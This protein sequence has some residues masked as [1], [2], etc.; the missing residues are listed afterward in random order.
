MRNGAPV[1][2]SCVATL[3]VAAA[4][5]IVFVPRAYAADSGTDRRSD[6]AVR[7][8]FAIKL[9]TRGYRLPTAISFV[10]EPGPGPKDPLYFVAEFRGT[11]KVVTNDCTVLTFA[12]DFFSLPIEQEEPGRASAHNGLTGLYLD[13]IHGYV[14]STSYYHGSDGRYHNGIVRFTTRPK[15]SFVRLAEIL[16][17]PDASF[18]QAISGH[19]IGNCQTAGSLLHVGLRDDQQPLQIARSRFSNGEDTSRDVGQ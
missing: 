14:F 12:H 15:K 3:M 13:P 19:Q 17:D 11:I 5:W 1:R 8:G 9:D 6:W 10:A 2:P 4:A 7:D 18:E 16:A